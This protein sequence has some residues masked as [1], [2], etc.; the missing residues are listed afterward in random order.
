MKIII[1][2]LLFF[3]SINSHALNW[4]LKK[5]LMKDTNI[6]LGTNIHKIKFGAINCAIGEPEGHDGSDTVVRKIECSKGKYS[7]QTLAICSIRSGIGY[8]I[9]IMSDDTDTASFSVHCEK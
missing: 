6:P 3:A 9:L 1:S 2:I 8:G 7:A 5:D 4:K